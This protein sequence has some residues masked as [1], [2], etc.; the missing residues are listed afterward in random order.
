[1]HSYNTWTTQEAIAYYDKVLAIDANDT[2]ALNNKGLALDNLV[3]YQE[4]ITYYDRVLAID[5]NDTKAL[6]NKGLCT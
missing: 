5:A 1:M 2:N 4:A 6:I 3:Q